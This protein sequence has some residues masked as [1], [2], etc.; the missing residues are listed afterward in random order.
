ML[1][2]L[3]SQSNYQ[4]F[5]VQLA[6]ILGLESAIYLNTLIEIN[7]KAIRKGKIHEGNYFKVDRA[8][9]QS[10]TTLDEKKQLNIEVGLSKIDIVKYEDDKKEFLTISVDVLTSMLMA[11]GESLKAD[12]TKLKRVANSK[13]SKEYAL[14]AV[15]K[16]VNKQLPDELK[17]AYYEWLETMNLKFGFVSK[18]MIL[19]A[20]E[21]VDAAA[22]HNLDKALEIV[23]ISSANGWKDMKWA[24]NAYEQNHQKVNRVVEEKDISV[25]SDITF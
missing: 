3:L 25:C 11:E 4:S 8:Y 2:E 13:S 10:R 6:H 16:H 20:Q 18:A 12:L 1:I 14:N 9:V 19:K 5:N 22:N 24:I 23:R 15:K 7:E 21:Q 17:A